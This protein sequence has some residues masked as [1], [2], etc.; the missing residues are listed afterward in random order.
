M[1]AI[2]ALLAGKD[3]IA[4]AL[5][6][7][8]KTAAFGIPIIERL[9]PNIQRPQALVLTP[10]RE[11]AVQVSGEISRIGRFRR[12][13]VLPV[14]GGQAYEHQFRELRRGVHVI[15]ATP[16]RLLDHLHRG[17]IDL[18]AVKLV[19]LDE[20]DEMLNMGF[21]EDVEAILAAAPAGRQT[22][23]F[24][25]TMP[26]PIVRLA[27]QSMREPERITLSPPT[28]LTVP[29]IEHSVFTVPR[30]FK[31]EALARLLDARDPRLALVFCATKKMVDDLA[32]ELQGR[33]YRAE[34]LHGDMS[35]AQRERTIQTARKGRL[36]VLVATDV[37]ARG[38]DIPEVS[39]VF[40]F[41]L[42]HDPEAYVHRIG[43]TGRAG[44]TGEALT[45]VVPAELREVRIIEQATGAQLKRADLP[46]VA[47][48]QDRDRAQLA[49]QVE[50]TLE[51]GD[52]GP[53]KD[54]VKALAADYDP[55]DL[56]SAAL[57]LAA[58]PPK[59]RP[60]IPAPMMTPPPP[61]GGPGRGPAR[62]YGRPPGPMGGRPQGQ[63]F[64]GG[65]PRRNDGPR[66]GGPRRY[67]GPGGGDGGGRDR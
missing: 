9:D 38:I 50:R 24:S 23:L 54:I 62:G 41:D 48:L 12:I 56:A 47:E 65:P 20:A 29:L 22:A 59:V 53:Y 42:P 1:V 46:S 26:E 18:G 45:L 52:W 32:Q 36:D 31:I 66:S 10:T 64:R 55:I 34:A 57:A 37:A 60:E 63:P 30:Q 44:R 58:G 16:G 21:Q 17:T 49:G 3:I 7:T 19:V 28:G 51:S 8:G 4:Q 15:V 33:G 25:A 13:F 11:L 5:T 67:D 2:P 43:R 14:Y 35:Q 39:H 40:N 6:G 27:R 61:R